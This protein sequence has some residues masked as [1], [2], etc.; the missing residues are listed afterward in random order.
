MRV[1]V[2]P[3]DGIVQDINQASDPVFAQKMLGDGVVIKPL[4]NLLFSPVDGEV[5]MV[6]DTFHAIGIKANDVEILL[7]IGVDTVEL[8]GDC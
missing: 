5:V 3:V 8:K 7:H 1:I 6:Y 2:N 4:D